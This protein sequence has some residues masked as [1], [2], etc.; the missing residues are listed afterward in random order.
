ML[1]PVLARFEVE[2][3]PAPW[4]PPRSRTQRIAVWAVA[5]FVAAQHAA[6]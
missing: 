2:A 6:R 3:G 4:V 5:L 1:R